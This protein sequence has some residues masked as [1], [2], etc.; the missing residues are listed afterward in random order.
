ME[1]GTLELRCAMI[2][3]IRL[4]ARDGVHI[5]NILTE[6]MCHFL[7]KAAGLNS[8]CLFDDFK[9]FARILNFFC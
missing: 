6:A 9:G 5:N 1:G 7:F 3:L 4:L 2:C 8:N